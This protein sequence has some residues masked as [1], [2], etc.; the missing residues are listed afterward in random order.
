MASHPSASAASII[1][2]TVT[3]RAGRRALGRVASAR[4]AVGMSK[5]IEASRS[6]TPVARKAIAG[7]VMVIAAV[8]IIKIA[9]GLVTAVFWTVVVAALVV[10]VLWALKTL[11]W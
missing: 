1:S 2:S 11:I 5:D 6:R 7:A 10:A 3:T 4:Y 8:V 9:I